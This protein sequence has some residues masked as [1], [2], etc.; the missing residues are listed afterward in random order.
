MTREAGRPCV[1]GAGV[2]A[3]SRCCLNIR[4]SC[5]L[6]FAVDIG[7]R[8]WLKSLEEQVSRQGSARQADC[9]LNVPR[10]YSLKHDC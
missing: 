2:P 9:E 1:E 4:G 10:C 3:H 6:E 5:L 7:T 8:E